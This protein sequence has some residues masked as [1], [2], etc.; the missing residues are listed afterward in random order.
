MF[1][2][3]RKKLKDKKGFTLVELLV[4]LAV[5]AIISAIAV[6]RFAGVQNAAKLSADYATGEMIARAADIYISV[7]NLGA[8]GTVTLPM[9][10]SGGNYLENKNVKI[11]SEGLEILPGTGKTSDNSYELVIT[12]SSY[13][14]SKIEVKSS[15]KTIQIFPRQ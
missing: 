5:L 10:T 4:V 13:S 7:N 14:V 9:L 3:F 1:R 8:T 11:Q 15:S 12:V 6:P 2:I